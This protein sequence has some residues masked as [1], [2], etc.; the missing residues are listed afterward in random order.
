MTTDNEVLPFTVVES[1]SAT[2]GCDAAKLEQYDEE[3]DGWSSKE[4]CNYPQVLTF[5]LTGKTAV[6]DAIEILSHEAKVPNKVDIDLG[7]AS[8]NTS[9]FEKCDSISH[10]GYIVFNRS[11]GESRELKSIPI[12]RKADLVRL[13]FHGCHEGPHNPHKQVGIAAIR[14]LSEEKEGAELNLPTI[15]VQSAA[16]STLPL[17]IKNELDPKISASVDR[18]ERLKKERA[19]AEDFDMAAR[20]KQELGKVYAL[21]IAFKES[22]TQMKQA[23]LD[24]DYVQASRLKAERDERRD[25]AKAALVEVEQQF[26]GNIENAAN[27]SI[28]TIKDQSFLSERSLRSKKE[29]QENSYNTDD[30]ESTD[31]T[32]SSTSGEDSSDDNGSTSHSGRSANDHPLAGVDGAEELPSP[33]DIETNAPTDLVHKVESL[34]G[35]YRAKCFFSKNWSLREACLA[36]MTLMIPEIC[37]AG[38]TGDADISEIIF[39]II[40]SSNSDKNVQVNLSG[41]ILLDEALLQLETTSKAPISMTPQ[42]SRILVDLFSKMADNSKK[43]AESAEV[44]L[45]MLGYYDVSYVA[46]LATKRVRSKEAKG[47]RTVRARLHFL[48]NLS[49][50]F[51]VDVAWKKIIDFALLSKAF[52]HRDGSVRDAAK[53]LVMTLATIHGND[54]F[55][56]LEGDLAERQLRELRMGLGQV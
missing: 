50:E 47:G 45:L 23:A 55:K 31:T 11:D 41:L 40:E 49:A 18:L 48:E 17:R 56:S 19:A 13:T 22:E 6:I 44:S 24:E 30:E 7:I 8:S 32:S 38:S 25:A 2:S 5:K 21:L 29:D 1:S 28:S 9:S 4:E 20:I 54:V 51:G 14:V 3:S 53:S 12:G 39:S 37:S 46:L 10:L 26:A 34:F 27:L 16:S 52:D 43:V 42:L 36:K 33:E 35:S 15:R